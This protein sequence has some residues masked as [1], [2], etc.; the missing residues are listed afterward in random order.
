MLLNEHGSEQGNFFV[1]FWRGI[2]PSQ[3]TSACNT[4]HS[5]FLWGQMFM[6]GGCNG[7]NE[8]PPTAHIVKL[9]ANILSRRAQYYQA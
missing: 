2:A 1:D 4:H 6:F 8:T 5:T 9:G 7:A 3:T